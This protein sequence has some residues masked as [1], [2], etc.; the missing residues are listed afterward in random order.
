MDVKKIKEVLSEITARNRDVRNALIVSDDGLP[1]VST[2]ETGHEEARKT[3]VGAI[4]TEAGLRGLKELKLGDIDL[5]VTIGT[6]GYFVIKRLVPGFIMLV[7]A[8]SK[9]PLGM[10]LMQI[11]KAVP[12][13]MEGMGGART[14]L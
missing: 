9:C 11:R 10:T 2:L 6:D 7:I 5:S 3:A 8:D 14:H 4:I 1:A 12:E 13:I